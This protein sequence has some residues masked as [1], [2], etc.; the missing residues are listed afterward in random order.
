MGIGFL[1]LV[2][3]AL[4]GLVLLGPQ[5]I[6]ELLKQVAKFY[7]QLRRTSNDL[8]SAFDHVVTE[9][10]VELRKSEL[11]AL[12]LGTNPPAKAADPLTSMIESTNTTVPSELPPPRTETA[13]QWDPQ[14]D[15]NSSE[16][17]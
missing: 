10:E 4:A 11:S 6:P 9:A 8:K 16:L 1:E 12:N 14:K 13:T 17:S 15:R 5:R 2:I 3:I 7:V